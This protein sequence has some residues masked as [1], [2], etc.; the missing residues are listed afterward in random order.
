MTN[1]DQDVIVDSVGKKGV[2][3]IMIS[4]TAQLIHMTVFQR[5]RDRDHVTEVT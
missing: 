5:S 3:Y 4:T 2:V 1:N